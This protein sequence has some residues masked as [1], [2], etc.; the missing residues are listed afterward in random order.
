MNNCCKINKNNKNNKNNKL[1]NGYYN[2]GDSI[3]SQKCNISSEQK[4]FKNKI[5][6]YI[7]YNKPINKKCKHNKTLSFDEI[8]NIRKANSYY[9]P[10]SFKHKY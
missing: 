7:N 4:L 2:I 1:W 3:Y 10:R 9:D 8:L 6:G 5:Q